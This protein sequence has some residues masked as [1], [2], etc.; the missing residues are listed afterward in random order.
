MG[1]WGDT[2]RGRG[3]KHPRSSVGAVMAAATSDPSAGRLPSVGHVEV[4]EGAMPAKLAGDQTTGATA[5]KAPLALTS[6]QVP[7]VVPTLPTQI[8]T[9]APDDKL[10]LRNLH[11]AAYI[12]VLAGFYY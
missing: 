2:C 4:A 6:T 1:P 12:H 11:V 8:N 9:V 3:E 10:T 5:N 7:G